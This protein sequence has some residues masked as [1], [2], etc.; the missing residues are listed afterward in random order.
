MQNLWIRSRPRNPCLKSRARTRAT[1]I[2]RFQSLG[3][4]NESFFQSA[5]GPGLFGGEKWEPNEPR[6]LLLTTSLR[7]RFMKSLKCRALLRSPAGILLSVTLA[8]SASAADFQVRTPGGQFA[9]QINGVNSPN[10]T[11]E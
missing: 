10:L 8:S 11:L 5:R 7:N 6:S 9:F 3:F 2:N 1:F 4:R